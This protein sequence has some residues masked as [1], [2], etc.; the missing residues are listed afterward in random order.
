MKTSGT[1]ACVGFIYYGRMKNSFLLVLIFPLFSYAQSFSV[2][3]DNRVGVELRK[4][5]LNGSM[6]P[7]SYIQSFPA[8]MKRKILAEKQAHLRSVSNGSGCTPSTKVT[9]LKAGEAVGSAGHTA[10]DADTIDDFET[11][12]I[13]IEA[14][15]CLNGNVA[16]RALEL[17]K[18]PAF[19]LSVVSELKSSRTQGNLTCDHTSV[20]ALGDSQ[21]CFIT[22][23]DKSG[24]LA[25]MFTQNV[26]NAP[27][28]VASAPVYFRSIFMTFVQKNNVTYSQTI[29]YIRGAKVPGLVKGIARSRISSTQT[30][31]FVELQRRLQ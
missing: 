5:S 27:V 16:A 8:Q 14:L 30:K 23:S 15:G 18:E 28:S 21:Y 6:L 24:D 20:T 7:D 31:S 2:P 9:F 11:G 25:W 13:R 10:A 29:A 4:F 3:H 19:Q 1:R 17:V 12:M 26:T 22:A